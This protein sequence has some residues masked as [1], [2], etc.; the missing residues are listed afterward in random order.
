MWSWRCSFSSILS[1]EHQKVPPVNHQ[2]KCLIKMLSPGNA[3]L[4]KCLQ[5]LSCEVCFYRFATIFRSWIIYSCSWY[6]AII[7]PSSLL[8]CCFDTEDWSIHFLLHASLAILFRHQRLSIHFFLHAA[9]AMLFRHQRLIYTIL[10]SCI[11]CY[12]VRQWRLVH[13]CLSAGR[14]KIP[15]DEVEDKTVKNARR[16]Q[17]QKIL[18]SKKG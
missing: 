4:F 9:L 18:C 8:L 2:R 16:T 14:L 6:T 13:T 17:L 3:S 1:S 5:G 7:L 11:S 10:S 12:A 15:C